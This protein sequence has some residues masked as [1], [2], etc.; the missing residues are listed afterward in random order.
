MVIKEIENEAKKRGENTVTSETLSS[1][2]NK[3]SHTLE[4]HSDFPKD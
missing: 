3:W 1:V 4:F 2:R